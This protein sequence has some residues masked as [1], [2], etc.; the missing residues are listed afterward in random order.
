MHVIVVGAGLA[1]LSAA[2]ALLDG[3]C[4]VTVLEARDRIG[5]R[6]CPVG[7]T[8]GVPI[9]LGPEWLSADGELHDL[10]SAPGAR[11]SP[12]EGRRWR[13]RAGRWENQDDLA[14]RNAKLVGADPPAARAR[15]QPADALAEC[16]ADAS[17]DDR[18]RLLGYVRGFHAAD[19]GS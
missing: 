11:V 6:V 8:A 1:G 10:S 14:D 13:R 7:T 18:S 4:A 12:S 3:G 19:P 9:E 5:G 17:D 2:G 16:C 15:P